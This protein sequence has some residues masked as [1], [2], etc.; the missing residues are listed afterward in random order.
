MGRVL[1]LTFKTHKFQQKTR[2]MKLDKYIDSETEI[3]RNSLCI[4]NKIEQ[5]EPLRLLGLF[6]YLFHFIKIL[7]FI[8]INNKNI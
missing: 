5:I 1:T 6:I 4:L 7:I 2:Q 8:Y 3:F